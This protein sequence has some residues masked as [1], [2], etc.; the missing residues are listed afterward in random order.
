MVKYKVNLM[1]S[2][3]QCFVLRFLHSGRGHPLYYEIFASKR[4]G[5]LVES[6]MSLP[7]ATNKWQC[8]KLSVPPK[9]ATNDFI[10]VS[11]K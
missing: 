4:F 8:I 7:E 3:K 11:S 6:P 10:V 9:V 5:F 1:L 2:R